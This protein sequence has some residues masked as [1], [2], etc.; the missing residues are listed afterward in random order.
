[1][2]H[3]IATIDLAPGQREKFLKEFRRLVPK[4]HA[5]AGCIEYGPAVDAQTGLPMQEAP[6]ADTVLV[7]EKWAD[8]A[9]LKT[10]LAAPHMTEYREAVKDFVRSVKLQV[11]QPA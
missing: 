11:L 3:V 6:R 8:V 7:I 5:E 9:A 10:H 2:I 1:M 4:V